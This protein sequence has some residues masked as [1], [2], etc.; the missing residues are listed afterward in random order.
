MRLPYRELSKLESVV[1]YVM[2]CLQNRF[3]KGQM[4]IKS[5]STRIPQYVGQI[6]FISTLFKTKHS[7]FA[8]G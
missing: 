4:D 5:Q 3:D 8:F 6:T 2:V 7:G 1:I